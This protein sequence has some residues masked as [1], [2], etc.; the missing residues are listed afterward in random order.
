MSV[1]KKKRRMINVEKVQ[2]VWYIA[3]DEDSAYNIL[4]IVSEDKSIVL[5]V[6]DSF[7]CT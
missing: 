5:A 1:L 7:Q 4:H 3:P 2:Y 6:F